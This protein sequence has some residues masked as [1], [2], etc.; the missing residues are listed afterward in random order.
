MS[1]IKHNYVAERLDMILESA[2]DKLSKVA[3]DENLEVEEVLINEYTN[4]AYNQKVISITALMSNGTRYSVD[5]TYD[6]S[7]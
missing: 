6:D 3:I 4:T 2:V 7:F 1:T 5:W